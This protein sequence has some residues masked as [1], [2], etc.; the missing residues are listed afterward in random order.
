MFNKALEKLLPNYFSEIIHDENTPPTRA[1][2]YFKP[3]AI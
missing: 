1:F 3:N 2:D